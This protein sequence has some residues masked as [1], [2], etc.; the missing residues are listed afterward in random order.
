MPQQNE[1]SKREWDLENSYAKLPDMF[2]KEIEPNPVRDPKLV[3][4]NEE[5]IQ[6]LG[7]DKSELQ[8]DTGINILAGN[9]VPKGAHPIAQAY[10]G[11]QFGHFTMLGDGRALLFGEQKTPT[12]QTYDIQLKGSGRTPFSRGGDGRAALGPMLREYIISE[13]MHG[14]NI[15]TTRSLAVVTTGEPVYREREEIGAIMTRV[16]SSHIRVGTFEYALRFGGV[17]GVEK[18]ADYTID[19]HYPDAR[20]DANPYFSLLNRVIN[21]QAELVSKWQ[22][23]GFIHG[24][25]NTDNMS[26]CGET[27]DY[28]PCAFMD[29]YDPKT[30][31]SSIDIQGRYAYGNQPYIAGWNLARFA[32]ALVPLLDDDQERA[33][34][35]AQD[36][37]S[38]FSPLYKKYWLKG[39]RSKL[40]LF[41]DEQE[42]EALIES[43]LGMMQKSGAD[44]TNTFRALTL[45]ELG[46]SELSKAAEF[47]QWQEQWMARR[48][49]QDE[50]KEASVK[51]M[52]EVNPAVIPRNH[53]V[54]EAL[55]AAENGDYKV[56]EKLLHALKDP[57]AY[58][59]EQEEYCSLAPQSGQPY[60]TFCG[61]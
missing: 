28:G 40:G 21:R 54:E 31:F 6:M 15:A 22:M 42:D 53:R 43:L 8:S 38:G 25:M 32:E 46:K 26:I 9:S 52:K 45:N 61:T 56:M 60:Q 4:L 20:N 27:I 3:V 34:E 5:V 47:T 19:R 37:I 12:G 18:L 17:E 55:H 7:L 16:A 33:V 13:A 24:V 23:A 51:L 57:Y 41:N 29:T 39:M 58:L 59:V 2:Y 36:A 50:S 48:E 10:A 1:N 49:R 30:V 11:H 44:F 14:L 35:K